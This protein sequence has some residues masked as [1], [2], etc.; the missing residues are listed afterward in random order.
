MQMNMKILRPRYKLCM[1]GFCHF[2]LR[3]TPF[4]PVDNFCDSLRCRLYVEKLVHGPGTSFPEPPLPDIYTDKNKQTNKQTNKNREPGYDKLPLSVDIRGAEESTKLVHA[5]RDATW[6]DSLENRLY[7]D[8][9]VR[10]PRSPYLV[11]RVTL[12]P[13]PSQ[14]CRQ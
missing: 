9:L 2:Q 5:L 10:P 12:P 14:V 1:R 8:K 4:S 7:E 6:P 11:N 13:P 3:L